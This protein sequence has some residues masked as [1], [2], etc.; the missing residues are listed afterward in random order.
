MKNINSCNNVA[1]NGK[2]Q[3][4]EAGFLKTLIQLLEK[5]RDFYIKTMEYCNGRVSH[6]PSSIP[7]SFSVKVNPSGRDEDYRELVR[8]ASARGRLVRLDDNNK[9]QQLI[10]KMP[11]RS[12]SVKPATAIFRIDED[13]ACEFGNDNLYGRSRSCTVQRTTGSGGTA[14]LRKTEDKADAINK[15][16]NSKLLRAKSKLEAVTAAEEK[17]KEIALNLTLTLEQLTAEA[18]AAKKKEVITEETKSLKAEI[19]KSR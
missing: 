5:A 1:G 14:R 18:E 10:S 7:R 16:L 13:E 9:V 11:P 12:H 2:N 4:R 6:V 3:Q 17:A 8:V 15:N 19:D